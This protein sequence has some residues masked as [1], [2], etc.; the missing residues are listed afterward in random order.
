MKDRGDGV[1]T[2]YGDRKQV[3]LNHVIY[4]PD[5]YRLKGG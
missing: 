4:G 3:D 2:R 5:E 1:E